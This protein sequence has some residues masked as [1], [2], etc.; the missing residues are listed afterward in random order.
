MA[1]SSTSFVVTPGRMNAAI[2]SKTAPATAHAGRMASKS[3]SLFKLIIRLPVC[4]S[5]LSAVLAAM[6]S[7][8]GQETKLKTSADP[9]LLQEPVIMPHQQMTLHLAHSVKYHAHQDQHTGSTKKRC[10][11]IRYLHFP[12]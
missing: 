8:T 12:I 6:R 4:F 1:N 10:H 9:A 11:G 2:S 5:P 3:L 7:G